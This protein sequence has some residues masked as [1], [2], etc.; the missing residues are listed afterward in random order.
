MTESTVT[1]KSA[2]KPVPV[3]K[4]RWKNTRRSAAWIETT[5][6]R[7]GNV[8]QQRINGHAE[9]EISPFDVER[10]I[11]NLA[12]RDRSAFLS[13]VFKRVDN[14]IADPEDTPEIQDEKQHTPLPEGYDPEKVLDEDEIAK[15]L[16]KNGFAFQSA[17]KKLT[18]PQVRQLAEIMKDADEDKVS[19]AQQRFLGD[20]I[21]ENL[22]Q[23][24]VPAVIA[25][26]NGTGSGDD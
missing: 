23:T 19:V 20:Y 13:G 8:R 16:D 25:E 17:V 1:E 6:P 2:G 26:L 14:R 11:S 9:F 21:K 18:H 22:V 24:K 4:E 15:I 7:T 10:M 3:G 12:D 5:D